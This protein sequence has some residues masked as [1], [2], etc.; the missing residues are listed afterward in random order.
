MNKVRVEINTQLNE[1]FSKSIISQQ[2]S[3]QS[4]N[5]IE[6]KIIIFKI[7]NLIFSSINAKIGDFKQVQFKEEKESIFSG[8][9]SRYVKE[10]LDKYIIN[11]GI[12][13]SKEKVIFISEFFRFTENK[14]SFQ[15]ELFRNLPIFKSGNKIIHN[16]DLTGKVEIQSK[17]KIINIA[18][19]IKMR[20]LQI[21]KEEYK[22][23]EKNNY[24]ISYKIDELPEYSEDNKNDYIPCSKIYFDIDREE[25][26]IYYQKSPFDEQY[27]TL[28]Y[29]NKIKNSS[30][31]LY[32]NPALMIFL[33]DQSG[34]MNGKLIKI[35]SKV[36]EL[37]LNSMAAYSYYQII[38]FGSQ[39]IK[40][41]EVP[42]E[43]TKQNIIQSMEKVRQ[44]EAN[45]GGTNIYSPLN[46]IYNNYKTIYEK[47][48]LPKSIILLT[49]GGIEDKSKTLNLIERNNS[50]F[51]VFSI[52][53]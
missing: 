15:F 30:K 12:I 44:L 41:E 21:I 5:S 27:Y 13:P 47:I 35:A 7:P 10:E 36:I 32:P 43:N 9:D 3:N 16:E 53:I 34:S 2:F 51:S 18:K 25:P 42:T 33:V 48:N 45:L 6:L 46:D 37:F 4:E 24:L 19:D 40:Y 29:V 39:Y 20:K 38:G 22:N 1:I 50:K 28:Q 49:D 23:E 26:I 11:M 52:G 14:N 31:N 8:N 17:N